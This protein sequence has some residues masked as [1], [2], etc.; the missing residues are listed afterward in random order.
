ML[1]RTLLVLAALSLALP[2][3]AQERF[4]TVAST[5]STEQSGLFGHILPLFQQDTGIAVRVV[6][7]VL[8]DGS[9]D[10]RRD[11][12]DQVDGITTAW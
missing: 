7:V 6:A 8:A 11:V 3:T 10:Q 5:T 12:E 1:R 4:I 2:A 9:A